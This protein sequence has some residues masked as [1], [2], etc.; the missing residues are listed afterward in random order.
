MSD[1]EDGE[2]SNFSAT[3]SDEDE[4]IVVKKPQVGTIF[5]M[6]PSQVKSSQG[7]DSS[8]TN[9]RLPGKDV[10]LAFQK[11]NERRFVLRSWKRLRLLVLIQHL[12]VRTLRVYYKKWSFIRPNAAKEAEAKA[13]EEAKANEAQRNDVDVKPEPNPSSSPPPSPKPNIDK[14]NEKTLEKPDSAPSTASSPRPPPPPPEEGDGDEDKTATPREAAVERDAEQQQQPSIAPSA[15]TPPATP[16]IEAPSTHRSAASSQPSK[17]EREPSRDSVSHASHPS[18]ISHSPTGTD[19]SPRSIIVNAVPVP[20]VHNASTDGAPP[21]DSPPPPPVQEDFDSVFVQPNGAR[22]LG[23]VFSARAFK[24][25]GGGGGGGDPT[26]RYSEA[27]GRG[28]LVKVKEKKKKVEKPSYVQGQPAWGLRK[29]RPAWELTNNSDRMPVYD[30]LNDPYCKRLFDKPAV[31]KAL[32]K[33]QENTK[34]QTQASKQQNDARLAWRHVVHHT[35]SSNLPGG[36]AVK[37]PPP[38]KESL[39]LQIGAKLSIQSGRRARIASVVSLSEAGV[40]V[41]YQGHTDQYNEVLSWKEKKMVTARHVTGEHILFPKGVGPEGPCV[42]RQSRKRSKE[43]DA[44]VGVRRISQ[45]DGSMS[46]SSSSGSSVTTASSRSSSSESGS[47][48]QEATRGGEERGEGGEA[49]SGSSHSLRETEG[50][51]E[52]VICNGTPPGSPQ[53]EEAGEDEEEEGGGGGGGAF[54][55]PD[56]EEDG[57]GGGGSDTESYEDDFVC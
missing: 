15:T 7:D 44:N 51:T 40:G 23:R 35:Y 56:I 57:G 17:D 41:H 21:E 55:A 4:E 6:K 37:E 32:Q 30:P 54:A 50:T 12:R 8:R 42:R 5:D 16:H 33:N 2:F 52:R 27:S 25:G 19:A 31:Q 47:S 38:L 29:K 28:H 22:P 14:T 39:P 10:Q 13:E 43:S 11:R 46:S 24:M 9:A 18:H 45:R 36:G 20:G 48:R 49:V 1:I 53:G 34:K 3:S 26:H